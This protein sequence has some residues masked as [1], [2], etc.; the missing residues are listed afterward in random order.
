[1]LVTS[2]DKA[3]VLASSRLWRR[4]VTEVAAEYPD[5]TLEH[6]YVDAAS[7][8]ILRAPHKFDVLL[9]DN[10]FGD[11]L[12]DEAAAI[13]GSI[14][15][16][17]SASLGPGPGLYEPIHGAAPGIARKGLANPTREI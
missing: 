7:F 5:V 6:R 14:G 12:S 4:V 3:N 11:I 10:L 16:L 1:K 15:V 9:T 2:V 13:A 8:E 17:P